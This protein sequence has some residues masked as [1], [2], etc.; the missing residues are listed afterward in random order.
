MPTTT[1]STTPLWKRML[2][3]R[4]KFLAWLVA[5]LAIVLGGSYLAVP[6]WLLRAE[7]LREAMAAKLETHTVQAGDTRW[8]YYEGGEGPTIVLLHGFSGDKEVWLP[9]AG[10]L[11]AHFHL[12]IPDL[13]GWGASSRLAQGNYDIDAQAARLDAFVQALR[14]P[15]FTLVGHGTGAAIAAAYAADHPEHVAGLALL[16]AFGLKARE[17][18]F[19]RQLRAGDNPYLF[20]DRAGYARL[21]ALQFE[22]P[23][24]QPGRFVD[25]RVKRNQRDRAFIQRTFQALHTPSQILSVQQRLGRLTMPVLGVWCHDDK[26]SDLSALDSLRNGLTAASAIS[27]STINGC[28]HMPMLEKPETTAQ[29]LTGFALSH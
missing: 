21:A 28:G 16:D 14:L 24:D 26:I 17:N 3:R 20:D 4:L 6:Q 12:V 11:T 25:V 10:L 19:A 23:P 8:S 9:L 13:P 29:I 7:H 2:L 1:D 22:Q 15:R 18:G 5:L 27:T